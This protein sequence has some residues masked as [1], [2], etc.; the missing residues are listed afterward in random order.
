MAR[1]L[2]LDGR[3]AESEKSVEELTSDPRLI[4]LGNCTT[5][6][7]LKALWLGDE[8]DRED[9]QVALLM[10]LVGDVQTLTHLVGM[11]F[12]KLEII[13]KQTNTRVN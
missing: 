1:I 12:K 7:D 4:K 13:A 5:A 10:Q 9:V 2:N 3:D 11:L 6:A 8:V